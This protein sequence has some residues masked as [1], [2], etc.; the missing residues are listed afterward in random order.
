MLKPRPSLKQLPAGNS[1]ASHLRQI[2][3]VSIGNNSES[4]ARGDI[5]K[6]W[7]DWY[8]AN[9]AAINKAIETVNGSAKE[10]KLD[11]R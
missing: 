7:Q 11:R 3:Q 8:E 1:S 6:A 2:A 10:K 5:V 4:V 9:K